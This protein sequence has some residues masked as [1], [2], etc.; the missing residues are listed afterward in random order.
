MS[1]EAILL[2]GALGFVLCVIVVGLLIAMNTYSMTLEEW[3]ERLEADF[4]KYG[5]AVGSDPLVHQN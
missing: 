1:E 2:V 5:P 4:E 3:N